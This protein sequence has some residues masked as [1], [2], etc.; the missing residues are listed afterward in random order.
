MIG[1]APEFCAN[2]V[3]SKIRPKSDLPRPYWVRIRWPFTTGVNILLDSRAEPTYRSFI[4]SHQFSFSV[5]DHLSDQ[6]HIHPN[7][8]ISKTRLDDFLLGLSQVR[9]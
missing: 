1:S 9:M 8:T 4:L 7:V 2:R 6:L 5:Q 3:R